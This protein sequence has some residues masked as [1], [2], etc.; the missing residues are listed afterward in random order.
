MKNIYPWFEKHPFITFVLINLAPIILPLL[1]IDLFGIVRSLLA[2]EFG[3]G[4]VLI[5][6][7]TL[8]LL[9]P[10]IVGQLICYFLFRKTTSAF[11]RGLILFAFWIS[12]I[13][14]TLSILAGTLPYMAVDAGQDPARFNKPFILSKEIF[15]VESLVTIIWVVISIFLLK[16][17]VPSLNQKS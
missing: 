15:I 3:L 7:L 14:G 2:G 16:R 8:L 1:F 12:F 11:V 6:P 17:F 13:S 9:T 4:T 5:F 10:W